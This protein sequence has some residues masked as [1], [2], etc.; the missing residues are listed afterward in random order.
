MLCYGTHEHPIKKIWLWAITSLIGREGGVRPPLP[1][2][3][4]N[5]VC[6][7][8]HCKG[9]QASWIERAGFPGWPVRLIALGNGTLQAS[10][11]KGLWEIYKPRRYRWAEKLCPHY[12]WGLLRLCW[13]LIN[14]SYISSGPKIGLELSSAH[15]SNAENKS[16]GTRNLSIPNL[17]RKWT[18]F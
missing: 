11:C 5:A 12:P 3:L 8:S 7:P 18:K 16:F 2:R 10:H 13:V 6:S 15:R 9:I 1:M 4:V 14:V 17:Y